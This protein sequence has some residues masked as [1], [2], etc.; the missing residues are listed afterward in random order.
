MSTGDEYRIRG[1]AGKKFLIPAYSVIFA[2]NPLDGGGEGESFH[3]TCTN[4]FITLQPNF[5]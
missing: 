1:R 2:G 5:P 4:L 3:N